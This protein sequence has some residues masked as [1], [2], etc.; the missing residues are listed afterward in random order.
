MCVSLT[1]VSAEMIELSAYLAGEI[2]VDVE[3]CALYFVVH[4]SV[5]VLLSEKV[6]E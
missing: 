5:K 1:V 4:M 2:D 6:S 3:L